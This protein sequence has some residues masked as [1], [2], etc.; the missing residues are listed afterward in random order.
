M[1]TA[2]PAKG[3]LLHEWLLI[4]FK[5][6]MKSLFTQVP[7][8]F[9]LLSFF[10]RDSSPELKFPW[11]L[12]RGRVIFYMFYITASFK[13]QRIYP[14]VAKFLCRPAAACT[15]ADYD[16]FICSLFLVIRHSLGFYIHAPIIMSGCDRIMK[17]VEHNFF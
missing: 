12:G 13:D 2:K 15:R 16:R 14:L 1:I 4:I 3:F 5:R 11:S 6:P 10:N 8:I 7:G 9:I 17:I